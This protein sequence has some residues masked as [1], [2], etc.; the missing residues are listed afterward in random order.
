MC[1]VFLD[2]GVDELLR[3]R[4]AAQHPHTA[5]KVRHERER[6]PDQIPPLDGCI[7]HLPAGE[8]PTG[9]TQDNVTKHGVLSKPKK[10]HSTVLEVCQAL[11][12]NDC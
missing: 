1:A 7:P 12:I 10:N 9:Q 5:L 4:P 8:L 2:D 11:L 6:I 3:G